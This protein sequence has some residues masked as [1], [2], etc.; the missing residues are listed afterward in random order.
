MGMTDDIQPVELG[1]SGENLTFTKDIGELYDKRTAMGSKTPSTIG[2]AQQRADYS[3]RQQSLFYSLYLQTGQDDI[4]TCIEWAYK[5]FLISRGIVDD[6]IYTSK[7]MNVESKRIEAEAFQEVMEGINKA[8][9]AGMPLP[10]A[11][12]FYEEESGTTF[13]AKLK[14]RIEKEYVPPQQPNQ[15]NNNNQNNTNDRETDGD[16]DSARNGSFD[17]EGN[18]TN[19]NDRETDDGGSVDNSFIISAGADYIRK[20]MLQKIKNDLAGEA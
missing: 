18:I 14:A 16:G 11:V 8:V 4:G 17:S 1:G 20:K 2:G 15:N 6:P 7:P 19:T 10:L 12:D 9:Q 5:R 13:S 3:T